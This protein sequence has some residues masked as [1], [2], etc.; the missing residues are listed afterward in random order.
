MT[1]PLSRPATLSIPVGHGYTYQEKATS[2]LWIL[3]GRR[4]GRRVALVHSPGGMAQKVHDFL[5][6]EELE[7]EYEFPAYNLTDYCCT[8][9]S[10]HASPHRGCIL[11]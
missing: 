10:T 8:L 11:R 6:I 7:A 4:S 1:E 3:T 5:P 2:K 9:I